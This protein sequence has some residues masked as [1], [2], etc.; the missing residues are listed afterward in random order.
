MNQHFNGLKTLLHLALFTLILQSG[1]KDFQNLTWGMSQAEVKKAWTKS[2]L[3]TY[4]NTKIPSNYTVLLNDQENLSFRF[5][6]NKLYDVTRFVVI[7]QKHNN[8]KNIDYYDRIKKVLSKKYGECT[9]ND[10]MLTTVRDYYEI[11]PS[12]KGGGLH[13]GNI[14][15]IATWETPKTM[16]SLSCYSKK[17]KKSYKI[18]LTLGCTSSKLFHTALNSQQTPIKQN[19]TN[20]LSKERAA[21]AWQTVLIPGI[22]TYTIP[23]TLEIQKGFDKIFSYLY[24]K[25]ILKV[26]QSSDRVVAQ[27]K[28][29]GMFKSKSYSRIIVLTRRGKRGDYLTLSTPITL[30]KEELIEIDQATNKK[31]KKDIAY[32][33]SKGLNLKIIS[34]QPTKVVRI[35]GIDALKMTYKRGGLN[36]ALPVMVSSYLFYNNDCVHEI[37]MSYRVTE[38]KIWAADFDKVLKSFKFEKR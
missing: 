30:S 38:K 11:N 23:P 2:T 15:H 5:V 24:H 34:R 14:E 12:E 27:P 29:E 33:A 13:W 32:A 8:L 19:K 26:T 20:N 25:E 22:C 28:R 9:S 4:K 37:T 1:A 21:D 36:D 18:L 6:N 35:N 31:M 10:K 3:V 16:V 7:S 17:S